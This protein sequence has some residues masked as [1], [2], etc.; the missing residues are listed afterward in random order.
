M[1]YLILDGA[2]YSFNTEI[3]AV[4][5]SESGQ[6]MAFV[7]RTPIGLLHCIFCKRIEDLYFGHRWEQFTNPDS[8]FNQLADAQ[9]HIQK[10]FESLG[11]SI[12]GILPDP[13]TEVWNRTS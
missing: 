10:V 2:E 13:C 7:H 4:Y 3:V 8:L 5:S 9:G 1:S 6:L 12:R 11:A